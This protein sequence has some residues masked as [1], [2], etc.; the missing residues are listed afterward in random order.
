MRTAIALLLQ[1]PRL[2]NRLAADEPALA[3]AQPGAS[4]LADL[5]ARAVAEPDATTAQLLEAYRDT[6]EQKHL[7]RLAA[8]E[9]ATESGSDRE[10]ALAQEF[11]DA[12]RRIAERARRERRAALMDASSERALT[13]AEKEELRTLMRAQ[14]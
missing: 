6:S 3:G 5:R 12:V 4:L 9:F 1:H 8:Y 7:E 11:D 2:G 14:P 10:Q 13:E